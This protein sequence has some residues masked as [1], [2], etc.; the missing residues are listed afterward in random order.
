AEAL[1]KNAAA[2]LS[3][4]HPIQGLPGQRRML[5]GVVSVARVLRLLARLFDESEFLSPYG[6]RAISRW[7]LDHP[8]ELD[9]DGTSARVDYEPAESTTGMFGGNSNWR[10]P[11]WMP[12]NFLLVEALGRY[13]RFFGDAL[14][15]EYPTGSGSE[16][17]LEEIAADLRERLIGLFVVGPDGRRP[18]FGW[19]DR[20]QSDPAWKDNLL[21]NEYFHGD[22]GAGLGASHQTGWTGLVAELILRARGVPVPTLG[23]L[24]NG[25]TVHR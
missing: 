5:L 8:F 10:G 1:N 2:M 3:G 21:F 7:H 24:M 14:R 20:L 6:L 18:C 15:L 25:D 4:A 16:L 23:A 11:V 12:V 17:T 19:V 13:A 9:V 22:N